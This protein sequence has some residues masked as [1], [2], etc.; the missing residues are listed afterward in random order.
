[1]GF[2]FA[3]DRISNQT[4]AVKKLA[5]PF[6][7]AAVAQHMFREIELLKQLQHENVCAKDLGIDRA[8]DWAMDADHIK[9]IIHL[10]D[11]FISPSEEMS[12]VFE[13]PLRRR[14]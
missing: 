7:T 1:V 6:I 4:V 11:I 8:K 2:S 14:H 3:K 9:Q 13:A 12:V 10:N 5:D